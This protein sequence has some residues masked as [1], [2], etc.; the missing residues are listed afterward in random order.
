[1]IV[2]GKEYNI[3]ELVKSLDLKNPKVQEVSTDLMLTSFE[4]EVLERNGIAY[5]NAKNL[6]DITFEIER[7]ID[8][9][10]MDP[11]D[12][13]ELEYVLRAISERNYYENTVK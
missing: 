11:D 13:D 7:I 4:I 2:N 10:D 12:L 5:Q 8:D 9:E 3:D 6:R 1:M